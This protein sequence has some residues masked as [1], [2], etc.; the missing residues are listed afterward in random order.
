PDG[1]L[2]LTPNTVIITKITIEKYGWIPGNIYQELR[3]GVAIYPVEFFCPKNSDIKITRN[4]QNVYT[5]HHFA[6]SWVPKKQKIKNRLLRIL[7]FVVGDKLYEKLR[8]L[9]RKLIN[10]EKNKN[11]ACTAKRIE[12]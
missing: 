11:T 8:L 7:R 6:G 3:E 1:R 12:R 4:S 10:R 2:D 5:I 9:K